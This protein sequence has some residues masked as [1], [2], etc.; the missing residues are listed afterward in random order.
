MAADSKCTS[1]DVWSPTRKIWRHGE[2]LIGVAGDMNHAAR[3][4]K[5]YMA[6]RKGPLAIKSPDFEALILREDGLYHVTDN[7]LEF[8]EE[9]GFFAIGSGQKAA[10]A[11]LIAGLGPVK[12]VEIACQVDISSGGEVKVE[13]LSGVLLHAKDSHTI[14]GTK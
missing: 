8:K 7:G 5:W 3:F 1:G 11:I 14:I 2:E 6:G 13:H 9:R 4:L 10:L 12:A